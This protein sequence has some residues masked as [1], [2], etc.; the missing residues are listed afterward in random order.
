[1]RHYELS[2][3]TRPTRTVNT[4]TA[5]DQVNSKSRNEKLR[6]EVIMLLR[7]SFL[8]GFIIVTLVGIIMY[9]EIIF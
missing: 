4:R 7:L 9:Y 3:K 8:I 2:T 6:Q 5:G 1:M